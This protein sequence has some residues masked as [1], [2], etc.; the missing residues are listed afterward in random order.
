LF[1]SLLVNN[2]TVKF[3]NSVTKQCIFRL[4][5]CGA[6]PN[7]RSRLGAECV[8]MAQLS[9]TILSV[10]S[11]SFIF[12][13]VE[14]NLTTAADLVENVKPMFYTRMRLGEFDPPSMNPYSS[15]PMSVVLSDEHRELAVHA[16]SMSL[17]LLKNNNNLLPITRR[18]THI[19][20]CV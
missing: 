15:I 3:H 4:S 1:A 2:G 16:A 12:Q 14:Q 5:G 8:T 7:N 10:N 18:F 19:A 6:E 11:A 13:A 20:V 9:F 17:V